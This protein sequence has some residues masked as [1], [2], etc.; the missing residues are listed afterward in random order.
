MSGVELRG[1][2]AGYGESQVLWNINLEVREGTITVLLGSNGAGKTTTLRVATGILRPWKGM[3]FFRGVN[4]TKLPPHRRAEM[5]LVMVPEGRRIWPQLTVYENLELGAYTKKARERFEENLELVY[6]LFPKLKARK[7]QLAGTLSGGERQMLA[8]GRALMAN[9]RTLLLDEPSLG[10]AP[11]L[12]IDTMD[13]IKRLKE[14]A[15][16]TVLLVEQNVHMALQIAD[17]GYI[18]EQG[19]IVLSG[20]RDELEESERIKKAYLGI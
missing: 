7:G 2:D 1:I 15:G 9:P 18:I 5:G 11:K 4:V 10:L 16:L 14:D 8:I 13:V 3:V 17:Y 12:V 19:R 20:T 6:N